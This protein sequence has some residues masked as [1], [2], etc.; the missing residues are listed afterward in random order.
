[1]ADESVEDVK[2]EDEEDVEATDSEE[3]K[4]DEEVPVRK[5]NADFAR[6]RIA[7]KESK[8]G[9]ESDDDEEVLTDKA[10]KLIQEEVDKRVAQKTGDLENRMMLR[11]Y[12]SEHPEHK[13]YEEKARKY[14]TAH[15]TLVV[16][17]IFKIVAPAIDPE[18]R[19]KALDKA[20]RGEVK[21]GTIRK[22]ESKVASTEEDYKKIYQSVKRGERGQAEK[23]GVK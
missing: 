7:L 22:G 6:T 9:K 15:P 11:D 23:L 13:K 8:K 3:E 2:V 14:M 21:G 4:V 18:E 1:M 16:E 20:K 5:G 19:E 17:D 10:S 12:L